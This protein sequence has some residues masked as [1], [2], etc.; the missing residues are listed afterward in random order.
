MV[1]AALIKCIEH[2]IPQPKG[3]LS[4]YGLFFANYATIPS[5]M[6]GLCDIFLTYN[7]TLRIFKTYAGH[8]KERQHIKNGEIPPPPEDEFNHKI[9]N[10]HLLSPITSSN[11]ILRQFSKIRL[12][13]S[14]LDPLLDENIEMARK[15][16][17]LDVD[18]D[19]D[20]HRGLVHGFLHMIRVSKI[21]CHTY[22]KS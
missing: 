3:I 13:T 18:V 12:L 15:L 20:I 16:R 10:D 7:M 19:I 8:Y 1:T 6:L 4:V 11:D 14:D 22:L 5:R 9:P 17:L 21:L 2:G